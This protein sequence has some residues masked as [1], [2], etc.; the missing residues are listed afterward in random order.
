VDFDFFGESEFDLAAV[1]RRLAHVPGMR[2]VQREPRTLS[3][4]V[5]RGGPVKLSFAV[6]GVLSPL[7]DPLPSA[8]TGLAIAALI[9]LAASKVK[10][11]CDRAEAKDYLDID[12]LLRLTDITLAD[13]ISAAR[14][15]YGAVFAPMP[16]LKALTYFADG[17]L[18]EVSDP[19]RRRLVEA[20]RTVDLD[21][22][23]RLA[24][25]REARPA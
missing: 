17:N 15:V 24:R 20:V 16:S 3:C 6:P 25:L 18:N 13:A 23:P 7:R 4:V 14:M 11:V 12:A 1:E 19:V 9:D 22:L 5:D 8:D 10:V 21:A 2:V